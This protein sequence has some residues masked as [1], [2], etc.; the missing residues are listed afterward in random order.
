MNSKLLQQSG[1]RKEVIAKLMAKLRLVC[2]PEGNRLIEAVVPRENLYSGP[3]LNSLP[4][5][6]LLTNEGKISLTSRRDERLFLKPHRQGIHSRKSY[7]LRL[8]KQLQPYQSVDYRSIFQSF[9]NIFQIKP[10]V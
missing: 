8:G 10:F 3:N 1:T 4:D 9:M 6:F 7:Y 5:I 2:D